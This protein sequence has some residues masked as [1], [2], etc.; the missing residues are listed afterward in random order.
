MTGWEEESRG[1]ITE[2]LQ[3]RARDHIGKRG[4]REKPRNGE[5]QT[6]KKSEKVKKKKTGK[7][8]NPNGN[9]LRIREARKHGQREYA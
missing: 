2:K 7:T 1:R 9:T 4:S 6:Q 3:R 5:P 8:L